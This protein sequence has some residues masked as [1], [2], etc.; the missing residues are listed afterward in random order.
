ML[1]SLHKSHT[2]IPFNLF[3]LHMQGDSQVENI[4]III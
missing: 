2:K 3:Y 4:K 1:K